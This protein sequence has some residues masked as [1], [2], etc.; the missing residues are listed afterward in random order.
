LE[1]GQPRNRGRAEVNEERESVGVFKG[2]PKSWQPLGE[3]DQKL[4]EL[5]LKPVEPVSTREFSIQWATQRETWP[6]PKSVE[7]GSNPV[8]PVF[9]KLCTRLF[10]Q[11]LTGGLAGQ[12]G[13]RNSTETGWTDF[14]S[15][16]TGF[17]NRRA[18]FDKTEVNQGGTFVGSKSGFSKDIHDLEKYS[19]RGF[20]EIW[21]EL[22]ALLT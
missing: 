4:V 12:S 1:V 15:G 21:T 5:V 11:L 20:E 8:E 2:S 10:W 18:S 22:S 9:E 16:W 7:P 17:W 6:D 13:R 3:V 19:L 14:R